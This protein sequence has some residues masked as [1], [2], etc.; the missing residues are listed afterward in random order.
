MPVAF[1]HASYLYCFFPSSEGLK[2]H[3]FLILELGIV[4]VQDA[5]SLVPTTLGVAA[6]VGL[7]AAFFTEVSTLLSQVLVVLQIDPI[8]HS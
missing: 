6:A 1:F 8:I 4:V 5:S 2:E 3:A 7:G